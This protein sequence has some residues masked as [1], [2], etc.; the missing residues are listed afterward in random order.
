MCIAHGRFKCIQLYNRAVMLENI[1]R[2]CPIAYTYAYNCYAVHARLFVVGGFEIF[3][4]EGTTQ[5]DPPAMPCYGIVS[6][7][8]CGNYEMIVMV[9]QSKLDLQMI[10]KQVEN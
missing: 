9:I 3:S 4:K 6:F 5:G 8:S 1:R 2:L 7:L 10:C